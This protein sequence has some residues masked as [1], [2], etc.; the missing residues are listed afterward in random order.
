M[1]GQHKNSPL[2]VRPP[3]DVRERLER[4]VTATGR[5]VNAIISQAIREWL[6]RNE[7]GEDPKP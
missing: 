6:D 1:P 3:A 7:N 5:A 2:R 4:Y